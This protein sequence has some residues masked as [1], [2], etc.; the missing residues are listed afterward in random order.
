[1]IRNLKPL[2][3]FIGVLLIGFVVI[4]SGWLYGNQDFFYRGYGMCSEVWNPRPLI[5]TE[6]KYVIGCSQ[7]AEA[8]REQ[9]YFVG[10]VAFVVCSIVFLAI[11]NRQDNKVEAG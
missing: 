10:F 4:V 3:K 2:D 7:G 8:R 1:M 5:S 9:I 11:S 6:S